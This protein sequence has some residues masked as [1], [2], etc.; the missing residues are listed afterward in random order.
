MQARNYLPS[1]TSFVSRM[2]LKTEK[3]FP[4]TVLLIFHSEKRKLME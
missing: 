1:L 3:V 4:E 2:K